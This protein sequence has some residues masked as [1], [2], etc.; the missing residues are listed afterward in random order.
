[1]PDIRPTPLISVLRTTIA[2]LEYI[3][4]HLLRPERVEAAAWAVV[5]APLG[6]PRDAAIAELEAVLKS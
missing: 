4:A 2:D 3:E 6:D 1:M 5:R